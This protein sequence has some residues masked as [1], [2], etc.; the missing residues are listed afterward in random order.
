MD[1]RRFGY[2]LLYI[3]NRPVSMIR[4]L[5][6]LQATAFETDDLYKERIIAIMGETRQVYLDYS[7]TT[8]SKPEVVSEMLPYFT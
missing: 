2:I 4:R 3:K 8:P 1:L 5:R 6:F 7:A